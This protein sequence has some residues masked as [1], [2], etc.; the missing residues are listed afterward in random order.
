VGRIRYIGVFLYDADRVTE[1]ASV[2]DEK[3]LME[4]QK[5]LLLDPRD[6]AVVAAAERDGIP[7]DWIRA[8]QHSPVYDLACRYNIALPLH[9]EY[10]T[11]P[12]VWY[13][14][15]LSPVVDALVSTG[16]DGEDIGNL[17]GA[18][19]AMRI[20][21]DYLA[22]LLTAGDVEPVQRVLRTLAA[23]R[24]HMR[25]VNLGEELDESIAAGVGLTVEQ[26]EAMYRLLAIAK[27]EDRY[28]IPHSH[29]EVSSVFDDELP[30][31]SVDWSVQP[32]SG[33]VPVSIGGF[34]PNRK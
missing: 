11:L 15:P 6:P 12:M 34:D 7:G 27:Y 10:R 22:Q 4:A 18:I 5:S 25:R 9:P 21:A 32:E 3:Q 14:P 16:H 33:A 2:P 24:A 1:A 8:A 17:F 28:V 13:V 29:S 19:D 23:M 30:G 20:P 26:I 31:C